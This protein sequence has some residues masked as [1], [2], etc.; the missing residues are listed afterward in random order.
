MV[1]RHTRVL[2][3]L[4]KTS[5][6][7]VHSCEGLLERT[8][9]YIKDIKYNKLRKGVLLGFWGGGDGLFKLHSRASNWNSI[10]RC[11]SPQHLHS[12]AQ[13]A[14]LLAVSMNAEFCHHRSWWFLIWVCQIRM[15]TVKRFF[16]S[17]VII[18]LLHQIRGFLVSASRIFCETFMECVY[19]TSSKRE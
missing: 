18:L 14:D 6:V 12:N 15:C 19:I 13:D 9:F 10:Q 8:V 16:K 17:T 4:W 5:H 7:N 2:H 11:S 3:L 1:R